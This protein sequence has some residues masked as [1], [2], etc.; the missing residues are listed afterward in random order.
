MG[1]V[2]DYQLAGGELFDYLYLEQ[3][4]VLVY[5]IIGDKGNSETDIRQVNQEVVAA[6]FNFGNQIQLVLL[7]EVVEKFAGGAFSVEH[8]DG[9][10]QQFFQM[11]WFFDQLGKVFPA[12]NKDILKLVDRDCGH[13]GGEFGIREVG[14]DQIYLPGF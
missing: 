12:G 2:G 5:A 14:H 11:E 7:E 3:V 9:M 10:F 13:A 1:V 6:Q 8:Q 4:G